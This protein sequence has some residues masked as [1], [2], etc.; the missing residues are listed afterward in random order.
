MS[1]LAARRILAEDKGMA[2]VVNSDDIVTGKLLQESALVAS[3]QI[4]SRTTI[5]HH[6]LFLRTVKWKRHPILQMVGKSKPTQLHVAELET[7]AGFFI[8]K[9]L[10]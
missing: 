1:L 10:L 6:L 4:N 5:H 7:V 3:T 2:I 8:S 9:T